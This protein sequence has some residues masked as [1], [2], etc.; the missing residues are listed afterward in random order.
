MSSPFLTPLDTSQLLLEI[1]A[2]SII[3]RPLTVREGECL[4]I[5]YLYEFR[6][7]G[8]L[9]VEGELIIEGDLFVW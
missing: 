8:E 7:Y 1:I 5:P 3:T 2:S 9:F 6:V 4:H